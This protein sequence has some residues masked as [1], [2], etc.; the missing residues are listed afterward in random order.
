MAVRTT[1]NLFFNE[2]MSLMGANLAVGYG[3][4]SAGASQSGR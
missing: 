1:F 3:A 4:T 2:I